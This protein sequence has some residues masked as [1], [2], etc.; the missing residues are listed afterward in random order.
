MH[1][2]GKYSGSRVKA[3]QEGQERQSAGSGSQPALQLDANTAA[4]NMPSW[5]LW[6]VGKRVILSYGKDRSFTTDLGR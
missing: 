5:H 6:E 2:P 4:N 3:S 1:Y